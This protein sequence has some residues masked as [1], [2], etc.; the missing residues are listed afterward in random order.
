MELFAHYLGRLTLV[1]L[2]M[3]FIT[4]TAPT[5]L[6]RR[7]CRDAQYSSH[8]LHPNGSWFIVIVCPLCSVDFVRTLVSWIIASNYALW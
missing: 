1:T 2:L 5:L 4:A 3:A 6:N 7:G 8:R